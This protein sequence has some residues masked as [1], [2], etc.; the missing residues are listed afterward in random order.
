MYISKDA[1]SLAAFVFL[2]PDNTS[3]DNRKADPSETL[4][5]CLEG[6]S[7]FTGVKQASAWSYCGPL[8]HAKSLQEM[9]HTFQKWQNES[10]DGDLHSM[11]LLFLGHANDFLT[12]NE[13]QHYWITVRATKPDTEFEMPRWHTD[14]LFYERYLSS[15]GGERSLGEGPARRFWPAV[16]PVKTL[17]TSNPQPTDWKLIATLSGPTTLLIAPA[18]QKRAR[19][20]QH[21]AKVKCGKEHVCDSIRCVGCSTAA[22]HVRE[23][24]DQQLRLTPIARPGVGQPVFLRVGHERG[25]VHSEPDLSHGDRVFVNIV[26]G[27]EE[28]LGGL[29]RKWGMEFPREWAV[30][31]GVIS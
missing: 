30:T 31:E 29:M 24:L 26:P 13:L 2:K 27:T 3:Q 5:G 10:V 8:L 17:N 23:T 16:S 19:R 25:A 1:K 15:E 12:A 20:F 9:P 7:G 14:D 28:E 6:H 22:S 11:L 18:H 21:K 4:E